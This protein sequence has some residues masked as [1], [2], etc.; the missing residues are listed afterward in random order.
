MSLTPT[1]AQTLRHVL[2]T[3]VVVPVTSVRFGI[4]REWGLK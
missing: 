3:V 1:A 4:L 2:A